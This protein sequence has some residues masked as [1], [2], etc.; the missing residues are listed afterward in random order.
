MIHGIQ[1]GLR[2]VEEQNILQAFNDMGIDPTVVDWESMKGYIRDED[3]KTE[4][5][6]RW[7][8]IE[9]G[10]DKPID[11][12]LYDTVKKGLIMEE[13]WAMRQIDE[14]LDAYG[15]HRNKIIYD[16]CK[17]NTY[18]KRKIREEK[19]TRTQE[20]EIKVEIT[21]D[22]EIERIKQKAREFAQLITR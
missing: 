18:C 10:I 3:D 1:T 9:Y 12:G 2:G 20:T 5:A 7:I 6:W 22:E 14:I 4:A 19:R 11:I 17:H 13:E 8:G 16:L 21:D 15:E